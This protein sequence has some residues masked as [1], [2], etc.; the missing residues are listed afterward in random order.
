MFWLD[1]NFVAPVTAEVDARPGGYAK[2]DKSDQEAQHHH[3]KVSKKKSLAQKTDSRLLPKQES[4][5]HRA[6][7]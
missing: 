3:N 2:P 6:D 5:R 1:Y 7:Q 4:K